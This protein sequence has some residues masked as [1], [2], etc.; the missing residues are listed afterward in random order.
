MGQPPKTLGKITLPGAWTN[1]WWGSHQK[2]WGKLPF[3]GLGPIFGGAAT[4]NT[5]LGPIFGGAATKN[6]GENYPSWGLDQFLVGQPPK[7]LGKITLPGVWT[8]F[9]GAATTKMVGKR[10]AASELREGGGWP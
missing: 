4:K 9:G 3:L 2:H 10:S 8:I 5:G 1:F 6:T 7:T